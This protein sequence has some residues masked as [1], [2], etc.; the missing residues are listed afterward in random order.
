MTNKIVDLLFKEDESQEEKEVLLY[1][2][3]NV[4]YRLI[5]TTV[6]LLIGILLKVFIPLLFFIYSYACLRECAGGYH[7]QTKKKCFFIS[8]LIA[9]I[10][11]LLI[12]SCK[13]LFQSILKEY[14]VFYQNVIGLILYLNSP[15]D[16]EN[17][18]LEEENKEKQKKKLLIR[19]IILLFFQIWISLL[20]YY[21]LVMAIFLSILCTTLLVFLGKGEK[22]ESE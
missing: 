12:S 8:V 6:T 14:L 20:E 3:R 21:E 19:L 7:A 2:I 17:K 10:V 1:G 15:V 5:H 9:I 13:E 11:S 4:Y 22:N 18:R 16:C